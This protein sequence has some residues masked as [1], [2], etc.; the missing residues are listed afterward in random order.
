MTSDTLATIPRCVS[1]RALVPGVAVPE[2]STAIEDLF[3]SFYTRRDQPYEDT[4]FS[5]R[6]D[7]QAFIDNGIPA[8]GLFTG[9]EV[10]KTPEQQAIWGGV[11]GDQFELCDHLACD[12]LD[13]NA[14]DALE[15]NSD[16]IAFAMLTYAFSTE[17]VNG[18]PGKARQVR[19]PARACWTAGDLRFNGWRWAGEPARGGVAERHRGRRPPV[20]TPL[21]EKTC[22]CPRLVR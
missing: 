12:T 10:A 6:S 3:E 22:H 17:D 8:G 11:A 13:N 1:V 4:E 5:G 15:L 21:C 16:A 14:D 19:R 18:V 2:G 20:A 9:A 7:Y